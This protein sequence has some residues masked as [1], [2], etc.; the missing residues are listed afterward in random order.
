MKSQEFFSDAS[1]CAFIVPFLNLK[2]RALSTSSFTHVWKVTLTWAQFWGTLSGHP[3][4]SLDYWNYLK[5]FESSKFVQSMIPIW[6]HI[7]QETFSIATKHFITML[8]KWPKNA[9]KFKIQKLIISVTMHKHA[10]FIVDW[11]GDVA[12]LHISIFE[13]KGSSGLSWS[14]SPTGF[15]QTYNGFRSLASSFIKNVTCDFTDILPIFPNLERYRVG[16]GS[17]FHW[18]DYFTVKP[19]DI[20]LACYPR[21]QY[22]EIQESI[23]NKV[24]IK[25]GSSV[26]TLYVEGGRCYEIPHLESYK[27]IK[28]LIYDVDSDLLVRSTFP[29]NI[30]RLTLSYYG[31]EVQPYRICWRK[32]IE[33][34]LR[35]NCP[36]L[37][38]ITLVYSDS[39]LE[40]YLKQ[41]VLPYVTEFGYIFNLVY[42]A[43]RWDII[44]SIV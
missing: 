9:S 20:S 31:G 11:F 10:Q 27:G 34:V 36:Q 22:V 13:N 25:L 17:T 14:V 23:L 29:P 42:S 44:M 28:H 41:E 40:P 15:L 37:M 18:R 24:E 43:D 21:L 26:H 38:Y 33:N 16:I 35:A 4:N 3:T 32:L 7:K 19:R 5:A 39:S 6:Q 30:E 12:S 2:D 8:Q 1:L